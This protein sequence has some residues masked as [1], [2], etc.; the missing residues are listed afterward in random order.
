[1]SE[2][3]KGWDVV[4]HFE[5][6]EFTCRCGC[7][8]NGISKPLVL[9]LDDA[10]EL[11]QIP[12]KINSGFRCL[13]HNEKIGGVKDSSHCKGL[14]VDIA[15]ND[16]KRRFFIVSALISVGFKRILIYDTFIHVDIDLEKPNP[17]IKI[18]K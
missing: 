12:F 18:M 13:K 11:A 17:I 4:R 3:K 2:V 14:A 6:D 1:M 10:R 8:N 5:N 16:D 7:D 15:C 9:M